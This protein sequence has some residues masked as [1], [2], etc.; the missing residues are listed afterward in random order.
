[1]YLLKKVLDKYYVLRLKD[2]KY[3][4]A[5]F[6]LALNNKLSNTK[7]GK[8]LLKNINQQMGV[9]P[10]WHKEL[11]SLI[12]SRNYQEVFWSSDFSFNWYN[13]SLGSE[14]EYFNYALTIIKKCNY[15][16]VLDVGCGWGMFCR[17][18]SNLNTVNRIHGI[19]V[20]D[21]IIK[22][23][24]SVGKNDDVKFSCKPI[25]KVDEKFDLVTFFG[26]SDYIHPDEIKDS[27]NAAIKIA[28]K[29]IIMTNS[30]RNVPYGKV[31]NITSSLKV[32]TYDIGYIHPLNMILNELNV[33]F[34]IFKMGLDSQIVVISI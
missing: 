3:R 6:E 34:K 18:V 29:K 27:I 20:S 8:V 31:L 24:Q 21:S 7:L 19:D 1:M 13:N 14:N 33:D 5:K 28:S 4:I 26:C 9:H 22:R 17:Y 25:D 12:G 15:E 11:K 32:V 10:D 2:Y 16:S 23:A 30:L